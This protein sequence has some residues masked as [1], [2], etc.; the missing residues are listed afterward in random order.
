MLELGEL[1]L[2]DVRPRIGTLPL[3]DELRDGLDT[4]S[5]RELAELRELVLGVGSLRQHREHEAA[6]GLRA[7]K[8]IGLAGRHRDG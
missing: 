7:R 6:L 8:R 1:P 3:L 5:P 2:A 4:R